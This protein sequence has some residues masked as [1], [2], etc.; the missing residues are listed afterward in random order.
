MV[1][2]MLITIVVLVHAQLISISKFLEDHL[3][4]WVYKMTYIIPL[5]KEP[6]KLN[7]ILGHFIITEDKQIFVCCVIL[8][9]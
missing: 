6:M 1:V 7:I 5:P 4:N 8:G 9:V 3:P 2:T